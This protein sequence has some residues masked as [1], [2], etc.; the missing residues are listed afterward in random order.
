LTESSPKPA[1]K[2]RW[3]RGLAVLVVTVPLCLGLVVGSTLIGSALRT[4]NARD[5]FAAALSEVSHQAEL[6]ADAHA[7]LAS[8]ETSDFATSANKVVGS[9]T[10]CMGPSSTAQTKDALAQLAGFETETGGAPVV[11][12]PMTMPTSDGAYVAAAH[13]LLAQLAA[14]KV[15][16]AETDADTQSNLI[17]QDEV[18]QALFAIA[19][20]V[21]GSSTKLV[22][23]DVYATGAAKAGYAEA[24]TDLGVQVSI[25]APSLTAPRTV[26]IS[27]VQSSALIASLTNFARECKAVGASSAAHK[28]KPV[29]HHAGG[30]RFSL[31][32]TF[33]P[34]PNIPVNAFEVAFNVNSTFAGACPATGVMAQGTT[35]GKLGTFV[36]L[37]IPGTA[38][39]FR[40]LQT[41]LSPTT[42]KWAIVSCKTK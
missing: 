34:S 36:T 6:D 30:G 33:W 13:K 28:P 9:L 15:S 16:T 29:V 21:G 40:I 4:S 39:Y 10:T 7:A 2:S 24:V 17:A 1:L 31:T 26:K 37:D 27:P 42:V 22:S 5:E 41:Y 8:S 20:S 25:I 12:R 19:E 32:A 18:N 35:S 14:D 23:K 11:L 3:P 38:P